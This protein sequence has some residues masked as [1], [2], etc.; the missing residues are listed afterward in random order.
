MLATGRTTLVHAGIAIVLFSWPHAWS[1]PATPRAQATW[2]LSTSKADPAALGA[3]RSHFCSCTRA[4]PGTP[5]HLDA[6]PPM[7]A[8]EV[9]L[10]AV[11]H[12]DKNCSSCSLEAQQAFAI[13]RTTAAAVPKICYPLFFTCAG[14]CPTKSGMVLSLRALRTSTSP[15]RPSLAPRRGGG[16]LCA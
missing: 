12:R 1:P 10:G 15:C 2:N 7:S 11:T 5:D 13:S 4:K 9:F 14:K 3:S 16:T 8:T 6:V